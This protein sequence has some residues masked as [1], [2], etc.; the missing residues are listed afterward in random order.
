MQ[1]KKNWLNNNKD[2]LTQKAIA[3]SSHIYTH[4]HT[5]THTHTLEANR[6]KRTSFIVNNRLGLVHCNFMLSSICVND[7]ISEKG[8][9]M[10]TEILIS[11]ANLLKRLLL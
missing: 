2:K 11:K 8:R 6:D 4:M 10:F 9:N 7:K 3:F 1:T 5:H